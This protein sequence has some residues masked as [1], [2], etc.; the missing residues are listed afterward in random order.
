MILFLITG[1]AAK[2]WPKI[3]NEVNVNVETLLVDFICHGT[4]TL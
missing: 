2:R 4:P 1:T 3:F